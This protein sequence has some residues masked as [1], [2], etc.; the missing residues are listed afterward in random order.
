MR[1]NRLEIPRP[2]P[3]RKR[4][5][6]ALIATA[7][8]SLVLL[9][10]LGL[11]L[12]LGRLFVINS[13]LQSFAD[14]AALAAAFEMDG[15]TAG[16][17]RADAVAVTGPTMGG[18]AANRYYF[19]TKAVS[20]PQAAYSATYGG[21]YQS[22][23]AAPVT[24]RF[25]QISTTASVPL[26]FLPVLPSVTTNF[27]S[28]KQAVAGQALQPSIGVG[29]AP[30]S[31]DAH[32]A[33]AADFGFTVGQQYTL[34]WP[35]KG[36]RGKAGNSCGGD[37]GFT[38]PNSSSDRGYIDV[39]Q[40]N[41][42]SALHDTIVNNDYNLAQPYEVG[43]LIDWV[44]GNKN[45]GPAVDE[46]LAQDT[47]TTSATYSAYTGNGRR[48]LVVPVNDGLDPARVA[49]FAAFLMP[50]DMC[51][52]KNTSPCCAEYL[53]PG[54]VDSSHKGS[55]GGGSGAGSSA[56]LYAVKLFR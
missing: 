19:S 25:V 5:G 45:V 2:G 23:A 21:T 10:V 50:P 42:N 17:T 36:Q 44:P 20:A 24:A 29:L 49:G 8:S 38:P 48:L 46:R 35:P 7:V 31:P 54:L 39:G 41:G 52:P 34:K 47:D 6:F 15:T 53:G 27:A 33:G 14:A 12:D 26:Y 32:N 9:A 13:E 16:L 30:F 22:S 3:V 1:F 56:G 51:E 43:S 18:A 11:A 4:K 37:G 28:S 55:G 40:G